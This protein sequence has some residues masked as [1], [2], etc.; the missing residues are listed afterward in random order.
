MFC[1]ENVEGTKWAVH[2]LLFEYKSYTLV[3]VISDN[4]L[5]RV[6]FIFVLASFPNMALCIAVFAY[7]IMQFCYLYHIDF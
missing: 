3:V 7:F 1:Y 2:F 6:S 4:C 5:C